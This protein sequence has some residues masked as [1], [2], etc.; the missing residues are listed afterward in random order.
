MIGDVALFCANE[1]MLEVRKSAFTEAF[2]L[3]SNR[4]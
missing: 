1:I 3:L 4:Y 2:T